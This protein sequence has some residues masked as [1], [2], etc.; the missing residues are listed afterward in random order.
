MRANWSLIQA[1]VV[2][3]GSAQDVSVVVSFCRE[4]RIRFV[5]SGGKHSVG[6]NGSIAGECFFQLCD[7]LVFSKEV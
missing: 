5:V 7:L 2:Y 1:L 3:V 4:N 6:G